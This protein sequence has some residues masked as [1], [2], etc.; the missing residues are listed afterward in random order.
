MPDTLQRLL[1]FAVSVVTLPIL[2]ALAL[3]SWLDSPGPILHR[4]SRV[5]RGGRPF[6]CFKLRTMNVDPGSGPAVTAAGDPR[7]TRV[8]RFLRRYRLDELPQL[9]NVARGEM[10]LVGPRPEA[11]LFVDLRDPLHRRVFTDVPGI[12]GLT[13]LAYVDEA[14]MLAVPDPE[15]HY[16]SVVLPTKLL[17][18]VAYLER[19]TA[20]LDL[21]IL[22]RTAAAMVGRSLDIGTAEAR[23]GLRPGSLSLPAVRS[24]GPARRPG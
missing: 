11:P 4:A 12:T 17:L 21:W 24:P 8:G 19:R 9:W 23:L 2:A 13:Q 6:T 20:R 15:T 5:G 3:L 16:Q 7:V 10:R 18:D 22:W 1:G 14:A